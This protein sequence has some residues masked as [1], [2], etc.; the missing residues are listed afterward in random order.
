MNPLPT[1]S[2]WAQSFAGLALEAAVL[3]VAAALIQTGLSS[4]RWRRTV[5]LA[6]LTGLG[7]LLVNAVTGFDRQVAAWVAPAPRAHRQII[8]RTDTGVPAV[9]SG[10]AAGETGLNA[11]DSEPTPTIPDTTR[12]VVAVW[13]PAWLWCL[14]VFGFGARALAPRLWLALVLRRRP[15][16]LPAEAE[17]RLTLLRNRLGLR[18]PVRLFASPRLAG[19]IAFGAWRRA[20]GLPPEFWTAHSTAEQDA[21]LAH[22][23]AHLA[24]RDPIWLGLADLLSVLLWWHPL[25]WW[26]RRQFRAASELAADEASLVVED[27]PAVLAGCLVALASRWRQRGWLGL[28]GMAGFRSG[29]GR[30]VERLLK[31]PPGDYGAAPRG[32]RRWLAAAA[33][34]AVLTFSLLT[35]NWL[36]PARAESPPTLLAL[37]SWALTATPGAAATPAPAETPKLSTT[38]PSIAAPT[39]AS[40]TQVMVSIGGANAL[41]SE[42]VRTGVMNQLVQRFQ[43]LDRFARVTC[44]PTDRAMVVLG[45]TLREGDRVDPAWL[46][47]GGLVEE[48][49]RHRGA[50]EFRVVHPESDALTE[51]GECPDGYEAL[52]S[53]MSPGAGPH[54]AIVTRASVPDLTSTNVTE[55]SVKLDP[56]TQSVQLGVGFDAAG[57]RQLAALTQTNVGRSIAVVLDGR[58]VMTPRINATIAGGRCEI[59]GQ[60]TETEVRALG[61]A[62]RYPLPVALQVLTTTVTGGTAAAG[63]AAGTTEAEQLIQDGKLLYEQGKQAEARARLEEALKLA[64]DS[65]AAAYYL[66]LVRETEVARPTAKSVATTLPKDST[67]ANGGGSAV[68]GHAGRRAIMARLE[69]TTIDQIVFADPGTPLSAVLARLAE[70]AKAQDPEHRGINFVLSAEPAGP[71]ASSAADV[72]IRID[73]GLSQ[74]TLADLLQVIVKVADQPIG[75]TIEDYGVVFAKQAPRS[76]TLA[77][78]TYKVNSQLVAQNLT[79]AFPA[80]GL[81]N[82]QP[83]GDVLIRWLRANGLE[84][85]ATNGVAP[86][87]PGDRAV[88]F[89]EHNGVL[90][91]RATQPELERVEQVLQVLNTSPPQV[92]LEAKFVEISDTPGGAV[93][94]DWY[95]GRTLM[96][97]TPTVVT[98]G[99]A[100][101]PATNGPATATFFPGGTQIPGESVTNGFPATNGAVTVTAIMSDPQFRGVVEALSKAGTN[102]ARELRGDQLDWPGR[103]VPQADQIRVTAAAGSGVTGVL[104]DP[105]FRTVLRGLEQRSGI[106]VLAAP[107]ITTLSG[108]PAQVQVVELRTILSGINPAA[109]QTNGA[110]AATNVTAFQTVQ[111][112]VGPTLDVTPFVRADGRTIELLVLPTVTEFL[113][114]DTPPK[115]S[116]VRVWEQGKSRLVDVPLPRFRVR[117]M[118]TQAVVLDG[119]TLVLGGL[120]IEVTQ[121]TSDKV[122]VLGD[123]P[124]AG[125]LFRS[126][127]KQSVRKL[128]LV[129]ITA[130][131]I[132]PA[133]NR[134]HAAG[135]TDAAPANGIFPTP[136]AHP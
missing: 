65:A 30:R 47:P 99:A 96:T 24:A 136:P 111:L 130:T 80:S 5:W 77:T 117:Q 125:R 100:I 67:T 66:R 42:S 129:F 20:I 1:T 18:Q 87:G 81:T 59:T 46:A 27:G 11:V 63:A 92:M 3:L 76:N 94:F 73:P 104:T 54:R 50:L 38:T 114:Y 55:A 105:Q 128:L 10:F 53:A 112:P 126:E 45:L 122:P 115:D 79:S 91:V 7:L 35:P 58:L 64:P 17:A 37:V 127:A 4:P 31:L 124:I 57:T 131:I 95:L 120:P 88:F 62:I 116:K 40:A 2:F 51:R 113:G 102:G 90:L 123:I 49:V 23:L 132:D 108:R 134:V 78:R 121:T 119:Q 135:T 6:A 14:G 56:L 26:A 36:L 48:I 21:M 74:V 118:Q 12:D 29:L 43:S 44:S 39:A 89:N 71:G 8:V 110:P 16:P 82:G 28:L 75:Y 103:Q 69:R 98:P 41:E 32:W 83:V 60:F 52:S 84:L 19:P 9:R 85:A 107:R 68:A 133:G 70:L 34:A 13:W 72:R 106:D 61:A 101:R 93:G 97:N 86:A 22:E 33:G 25:V 15:M 109:R